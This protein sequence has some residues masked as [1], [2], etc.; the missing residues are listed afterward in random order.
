MPFTPIKT[1]VIIVLGAGIV[2][3][4]P[5]AATAQTVLNG[6]PPVANS[7]IPQASG[8]AA[9]RPMAPG[10]LLRENNGMLM[11]STLVGAN[12]Y[13]DYGRIVGTVDDLLVSTSGSVQSVVLSVGGFLGIGTHYV[14]VPMSGLKIEPSDRNGLIHDGSAGT[15]AATGIPPT[16]GTQVGVGVGA[17]RG[18]PHVQYFSLVLPGAT[19]ASL[20]SMPEFKFNS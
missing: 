7:H 9:P 10:G 8:T 12:V 20:K 2:A 4:A 3:A 13:N 11:S 18:V 17:M 6:T 14:A 5:R 15:S 16:G 1:A 19:K